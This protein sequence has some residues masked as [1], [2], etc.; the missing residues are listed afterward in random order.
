M[1]I[2]KK[3]EL[4]TKVLLRNKSPKIFGLPYLLMVQSIQDSVISRK[5]MYILADLTA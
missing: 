1:H 5:Y 2:A 3:K 4:I